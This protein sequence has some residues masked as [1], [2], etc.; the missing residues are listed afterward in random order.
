[1]SIDNS[2]DQIAQHFNGLVKEKPKADNTFIS[3]EDY[4][5]NPETDKDNLPE[6]IF[7]ALSIEEIQ[8]LRN[9]YSPEMPVKKVPSDEQ[10]DLFK[11]SL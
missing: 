6:N 5:K 3:P 9:Q 11:Q 8:K 1:M 4:F 2:F 10:L 7:G